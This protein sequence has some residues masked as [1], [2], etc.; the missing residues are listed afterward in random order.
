M[1]SALSSS[2]YDDQ[3]SPGPSLT[4]SP[5]RSPEAAELPNTSPAQPPTQ[6]PWTEAS[7]RINSENQ[8]RAKQRAKSA[9][10]ALSNGY[11]ADDTDEMIDDLFRTVS[12]SD[13]LSHSPPE[14]GQ[15]E[16]MENGSPEDER[17]LDRTLTGSNTPTSQSTPSR[18][19]KRRRLP[20]SIGYEQE[21][22]FERRDSDASSLLFNAGLGY[23]S[24]DSPILKGTTSSPSLSKQG[25]STRLSVQRPSLTLMDHLNFDDHTAAE[26]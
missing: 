16:R 25:S 11:S 20:N 14:D 22:S 1:V 26:M 21:T 18:K 6:V 13:I 2:R 9:D 24:P 15:G 23:L 3:R 8:S 12:E 10:D 19:E 4:S 5:C 7:D 17:G